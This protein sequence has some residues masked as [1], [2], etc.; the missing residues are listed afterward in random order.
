MR[1]AARPEAQ[2]AARPRAAQQV[3]RRAAAR[4][5]GAAGG[6]I[7]LLFGAQRATLTANLG[8]EVQGRGGLDGLDRGRGAH[9][10][11][12]RVRR[13]PNGQRLVLL[14]VEQPSLWRAVG[15]AVLRRR[16]RRL[17][18]RLLAGVGAAAADG[19]EPPPQ[20][21]VEVPEEWL[22]LMNTQMTFGVGIALTMAVK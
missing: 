22:A 19:D 12:P 20:A 16:L 21:V 8:G 1:P 7:G 4:R 18:Q 10:G 17:Q 11:S 9:R 6:A 15:A 5:A 13:R 14:V 2:R 3:A